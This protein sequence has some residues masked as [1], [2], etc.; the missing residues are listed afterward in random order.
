MAV[1]WEQ[2]QAADAPR[3]L[4]VSGCSKTSPLSSKLPNKAEQSL[5]KKLIY[6]YLKLF[7]IVFFNI[8]E[9]SSRYDVV[10][11]ARQ[12]DHDLWM[13][14]PELKKRWITPGFAWDQG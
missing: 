6:P 13:V 8:H 2:R 9:I 5:S 7:I 11:V 14:I 1:P 4:G 10:F 12:P 3:V